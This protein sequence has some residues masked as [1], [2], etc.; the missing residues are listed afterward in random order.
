[1]DSHA[2]MTDPIDSDQQVYFIRDGENGGPTYRVNCYDNLIIVLKVINYMYKGKNIL[3]RSITEDCF[4]PCTAQMIKDMNANSSF[5]LAYI[6]SHWFTNP[7]S[8]S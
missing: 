6:S 2:I 5:E 8:N 7:R 3:V 4:H 1:M